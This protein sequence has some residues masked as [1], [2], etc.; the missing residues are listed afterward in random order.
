MSDAPQTLQD[1]RQKFNN[2]G[3]PS[4]MTDEVLEKLEEAFLLG[5]TDEEACLIANIDPKTLYNYCNKHPEFS[6]RK[7]VLKQHP[8]IMARRN[9]IES[10]GRR[11][12]DMS[13]WYL[14]RKTK[15]FKPKADMTTDDKPITIEVINYGEQKAAPTNVVDSGSTD[16]EVPTET[17]VGKKIEG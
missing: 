16:A 4:V 12:V 8:T 14:E 1:I 17:M 2:V 13:R 6:S 3:R 11:D 9:V 5:H 7:E 15:E 10:L